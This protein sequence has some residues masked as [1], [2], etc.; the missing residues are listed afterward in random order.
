MN[1][2][3]QAMALLQDYRDARPDERKMEPALL[4]IAGED[5]AVIQSL[6]EHIIDLEAWIEDAKD[7]LKRGG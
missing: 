3:D 6:L 7:I 1:Y 5:L 4:A 2:R